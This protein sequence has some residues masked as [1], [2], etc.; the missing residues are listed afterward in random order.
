MT[1]KMID[2]KFTYFSRNPELRDEHG[3][4]SLTRDGVKFTYSDFSSGGVL[5]LRVKRK[6]VFRYDLTFSNSCS[7][8]YK[9]DVVGFYRPKINELEIMDALSKM[10]YDQINYK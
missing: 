4:F 6:G 5:F 2:T 9:Y 8:N 1:K 10:G 3:F 7:D